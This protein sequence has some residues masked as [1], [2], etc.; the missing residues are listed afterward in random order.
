MSETYGVLPTG[1]KRKRLDTIYS[2]VCEYFK[3]T[4][5]VDPSENSQSFFAVINQSYSDQLEQLWEMAEA[6][7]YQLYPGTAD[8]VNLDNDLQLAGF[9]RKEKKHSRYVLACT[10][11]DGTV[12]PYGSLVK[13][14]TQPERQ[15]QASSIQSIS[16]ENFWKIKV[17]PV[18]TDVSNTSTYTI[19]LHPNVDSGSVGTVV[20]SYTKTITGCATYAEAYNA[21]KA[22]F[23]EAATKIGFSVSEED[24]DDFDDEG[25]VVKLIVATGKKE[26][27][28]F[29]A[30]LT[31]NVQVIRVT[32]NLAFETTEYGDISLP[33]GTITQIVTGVNGFTDVNNS[34]KYSPGRLAE[35]DSEVRLRYAQGVAIR[36]SGT[37]ERICAALL[38]DVDGCDYAQGYEN[39]TDSVDSEGRPP[40][41]IEIV[42]RGGDDTEVAETIW[43]GK[44]AGIRSYGQHYAYITDSQGVQQYVQFSRI[45][46]CVLHIKVTLEVEKDALDNNYLEKIT[47]ILTGIEL[48]AGE[49]VKMQESLVPAIMRGVNGITYIDM[50]GMLD[51]VDGSSSGMY[52]HGT[53]SVGLRQ[54]PVITNDSIQVTLA[55]EG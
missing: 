47:S 55:E 16:R 2:D 49:N 14:T 37:I 54:Q 22:A 24:T 53:I 36:A 28:S 51:A 21:M 3:N 33:L 18:L 27:D 26:D 48:T 40:H 43:S 20:Q 46:N 50:K 30:E 19:T 1:F 45:E 25:N 13:S 52:K 8:G 44:A 9:M 29:Y 4:I 32:S 41:S 15:L 23:T 39:P 7:Y 31:P 17:R 12:I 35:T 5:G 38:T 10:G 6:I 42:A 34:I 11:E